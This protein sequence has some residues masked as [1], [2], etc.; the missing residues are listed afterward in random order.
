MN[1]DVC[2]RVKCGKT[3][4]GGDYSQFGICMAEVFIRNS[5][6][7][8]G[9]IF[10]SHSSALMLDLLHCNPWLSV[11]ARTEAL[12]LRGEPCGFAPKEHQ[13][14]LSPV[15]LDISWLVVWL[16][17]LSIFYFPRNIGNVIIP[18]DELIFFRGFFQPPTSIS[19]NGWFIREIP[20]KRMIF[21]VPH[22]W[23]P[24]YPLWLNHVESSLWMPFPNVDMG[25][26]P[27]AEKPP[28]FSFGG[29]TR[30]ALGRDLRMWMFAPRPWVI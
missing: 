30:F 4:K 6:F 22:L 13:L 12:I 17:C 14:G 1:L 23:K 8:C 5:M 25:E 18:I 28:N 26:D 21:G 10:S 3:L 29:S 7:F 11:S 19:Q 20:V 15:G 27:P 2:W 16:P 24:P 9:V